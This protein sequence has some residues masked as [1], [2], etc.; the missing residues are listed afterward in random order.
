MIKSSANYFNASNLLKITGTIINLNQ[1]VAIMFIKSSPKLKMCQL[2]FTALLGVCGFTQTALATT[3]FDDTLQSQNDLSQLSSGSG[4]IAIAPDGSNALTFTGSSI[5]STLSTFTST[6]GS[7][8]VS[9][10]L[11]G[12][13]GQTSGCGAMINASANPFNFGWMLA[14]TPYSNG[15]VG[16][17]Q[18][19]DT[20]NGVWEQ[21]SYTF[22]G[23]STNLGLEQYY[24]APNLAF[25][26]TKSIF[27]KNLVLTDNSVGTAINTLTVSPVAAVPLPPSLLM[28]ASGLLGLVALR[29]KIA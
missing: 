17:T 26:S 23:T 28:F 10:D 16:V 21:V 24:G 6:T 8:T 25:G 27:F 14:D 4:F 5:I 7:F 29:R 9:F 3:L 12:N 19:P 18:I 13:C 11:L 1:L 2:A 20:I 22:S 15:S